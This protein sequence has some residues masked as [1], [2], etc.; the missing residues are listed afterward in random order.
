MALRRWQT[1]L[2]RDAF[3]LFGEIADKGLQESLPYL[4]PSIGSPF[5]CWRIESAWVAI[6]PFASQG[7]G[8][9]ERTAG[10]RKG[11]HFH[12]EAMAPAAK[13]DTPSKAYEKRRLDS[14]SL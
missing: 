3:I 8:S 11:K 14:I 13:G 9:P 4:S 7:E 1:L 6:D 12:T 5:F 2:Q 10:K